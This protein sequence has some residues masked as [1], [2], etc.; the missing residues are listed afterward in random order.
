MLFNL[1]LTSLTE[2]ADSSLVGWWK[3]DET[4]GTT[5]ADSSGNGHPGTLMNGPIWVTGQIMGALKFDGVNDYVD[6]G[7]N[8][9]F[10][11]T[12][13]VT[14]ALWVNP[15]DIGN[16]QD[17]EWLGKGDHTYCLKGFRTGNAIEW[18]VYS[19]GGWRTAV[20]DVGTSFNGTWHHVA[21]TFDGAALKLYVDGVL[22]TTTAYAGTIET[23]THNINMARNSEATTRFAQVTIDDARIYNRALS[24]AEIN[25]I[26]KGETTSG[27]AT[28]PSPIDKKTDVAR[29][30]V[31]GWKPGTYAAKHNV[32]FGTTSAEVTAATTTTHP[33]VQV[34][35]NQDAN[36]YDPTGVLNFNQTYYWRVDEINAPPTSLTIFTGDIW[37]FTTETVSYQITSTINATASSYTTGMEPGKTI[38]GSGIDTATDQHGT[39]DTTMWLSGDDTQPP[40]IQYQFDKVYKLNEMWVWNSNQNVES[41]I[42]LGIK[43]VKVEYSID[44]NKY[45]WTQLSSVSEFAQAPGAATYVHNTTVNFGGIAARY[46]RITALSN[47]KGLVPKYGLSE[48]RFFYI[49]V[50]A[51]EPNPTNG[52]TGVV[53]NPVLRWRAGRE[54]AQHKLYFST[55]MQD[56]NDGTV[57]PINIPAGSSYASYGPLSLDLGKTYYWKVNE[58]NDA[59]SIPTWKGDVWS[60]STVA[61]LTVEGFEDYNNSSPKRIFQTWLDG[62]GY[63]ADE[64]FP[65]AYNGNGTGAAVGHDIWTPGTTYTNIMETTIRN[66]GAQSMP[67]YYNNTKTPFYSETERTFAASQNWTLASARSLTL[68]FHGDPNNNINEPMWVRLTDQNGNS[69][70]ITYGKY[71]DEDV[72]NI[73]TA[74]WRQWNI[75]LA[76]FTGVNPAQ[77]KK[78][79]IGFSESGGASPKSSGMVYIDDIRLYPA[80]CLVMRVKPTGDLNNDCAVDYNDIDILANAWL[81]A[82]QVIT[83]TAPATTGLFGNWKFDDG[84]GTTA[85]D[86]SGNSYTGTLNGTPKWVTGKIGGALRFNGTTDYVQT[87]TITLNSD[88]VT[89]TA[90]IKRD[91]DQTGWSGIIFHRTTSVACGIGFSGFT[92]AT[93]QL[94]YTWNNNTAAT[95]NWVSGLTVPNNEWAFVAM[96]I[97]PTKATL[98]LNGWSATN[99][100]AHVTQALTDI[101]LGRDSQGGRFFRGVI[102]DARV[103]SRTLSKAELAY[104]A[105]PTPGDGQLQIPVQSPA[106]LYSGETAGSRKVNFKDF[107]VLSTTWLEEKLWP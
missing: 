18:F 33:N 25:V 22:R 31:L 84:S 37:S 80:R 91:G 83:T 94:Q 54:A 45:N 53:I 21:G 70:K 106:E 34:S 85:A 48:V 62:V 35:L 66:S 77:I 42:G 68:Y 101:N 32:Y 92:G 11:I 100:I 39:T 67:L 19:A 14:V 23:R 15:L 58:V 81:M 99:A 63:S 64:F 102:D 104:M 5:A 12:Q 93:N 10:D 56:V 59:N 107:A 69:K 105:D 50:Q 51:R 87:G 36:T 46:V 47:W 44:P 28:I 90:W 16:T 17:N 88:T 8:A 74:A 79:A 30:V 57:A 95:Y 72:N 71:A 13:Q 9:V 43:S 76:D 73:A 89:M 27:K 86:S 6:C 2:G 82:D 75:S 60:F 7:N 96:T 65:V 98:Y 40:W 52:Q 55:K 26:M 24:E 29:D 41:I 1:V 61:Y 38:D 103:Y 49:P 97:E 20:V 4:A 78:I 3:L